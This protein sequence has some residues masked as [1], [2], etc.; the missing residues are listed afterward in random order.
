MS[1]PV[2]PVVNRDNAYFFEGTRAQEPAHPEVQRLR[3]APPPAR[4]CVS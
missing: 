2:R 4:P 3:G 1:G